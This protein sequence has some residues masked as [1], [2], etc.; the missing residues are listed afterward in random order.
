MSRDIRITLPDGS[1]RPMPAGTTARAVAES[2][3][4]RLAKDAVAANVNGEIWDLNRAI[5]QDATIEILTPRSGADA[6]YVLRHS[7]AHVLA[8]AVRQLFPEAG[9]GFGPP[10]DD[11]FYY[12]FEVPKPFTPEDL[13]RITQR[14][15]EVVKADYQFVR[16]E[17]DRQDARQR[18]K[19][20]PLK[21]ERLEELKDDEVISVYTDGRFSLNIGWSH[22]KLARLA[23]DLPEKYRAEA[24]SRL[25][26]DFDRIKW[27]RGWPMA[28]LSAL[29]PDNAGAFKEVV[30]QFVSEVGALASPS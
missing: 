22:Q 11:G 26:L 21:L 30:R 12:D 1:V 18:F 5:Q 10:I 20:D 28:K 16:E 15:Q 9:I 27:E 17:V 23:A 14:M 13:E 4:P 2:I 8:T 6:L 24:K 25:G 7:S 19:D 3:G 29:L